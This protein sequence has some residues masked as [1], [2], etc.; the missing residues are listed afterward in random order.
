MSLTESAG[1]FIYNLWA[2][3]WGKAILVVACLALF[4]LILWV[5]GV[6]LIGLLTG[7][8]RFTLFEVVD[9]S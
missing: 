3:W 1:S 8:Y 5:S 9:W 2:T 4:A 7:K 6:S